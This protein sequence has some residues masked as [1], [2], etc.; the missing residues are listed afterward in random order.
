MFATFGYNPC[1]GKV[2]GS[3][4]DNGYYYGQI[5]EQTPMEQI[6]KPQGILISL[7]P[8]LRDQGYG[9]YVH[10]VRSE[11]RNS[12]Y[13]SHVTIHQ[14][15]E[16]TE[17]G[18]FELVKDKNG[19]YSNALYGC[20]GLDDTSWFKRKP[21]YGGKGGWD[22]WGGQYPTFDINAAWV[23]CN[24]EPEQPVQFNIITAV[25]PV[26]TSGDGEGIVIEKGRRGGVQPYRE[27]Q[28]AKKNA[29]PVMITKTRNGIPQPEETGIA[30]G[31]QGNRA[32]LPAP[33]GVNQGYRAYEK[34]EADAKAA[35]F[36]PAKLVDTLTQA[37]IPYETGAPQ[38]V[39]QLVEIAPGVEAQDNIRG[40][41]QGFRGAVES[42]PGQAEWHE[43][44]SQGRLKP[45]QLEWQER[46]AQVRPGTEV[47]IGAHPAKRSEQQKRKLSKEEIKAMQ[48]RDFL[49][50]TQPKA[51]KTQS[52]PNV[53]AHKF[54][55]KKI[56]KQ[57]V[58]T[59]ER[60][61]KI[62]RSDFAGL[63]LAIN[64][65]AHGGTHSVNHENVPDAMRKVE[66]KPTTTAA[67]E[68]MQKIEGVEA[69]QWQKRG[70]AW[71]PDKLRQNKLT[72][73]AMVPE[74]PRETGV[75]R[76]HTTTW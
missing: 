8:T 18:G 75:R 47:V 34:R 50:R 70:V 12:G 67:V 23:Q 63:E 39:S 32:P 35:T 3:I 16:G 53:Q 2:I 19:H 45:G 21:E 59:P 31:N 17:V 49:R 4:E 54:Q 58:P 42:N 56:I 30:S 71:N 52:K 24:P 28:N 38:L 60:S 13:L 29:A 62:K 41:R 1:S 55:G 9:A 37:S 22:R 64:A 14:G 48:D 11:D 51:D 5:L 44:V 20:D 10:E 36:F 66:D 61:A 6:S 76:Y 40:G 65:L 43:R 46:V 25:V 69:W 57:G 68:T 26:Q 72:A 74:G 33:R 73:K 7:T 15:P 27:R